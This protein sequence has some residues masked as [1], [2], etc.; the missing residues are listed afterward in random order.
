MEWGTQLD[1]YFRST[2]F[3]KSYFMCMDVPVRFISQINILPKVLFNVCRCFACIYGFV[4]S[5]VP[6][7]SEEGIDP[8]Q[9]EFREL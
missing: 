5:T 3:L 4:P 8:L 6:T 9:L 2:Y 1:L 7:G